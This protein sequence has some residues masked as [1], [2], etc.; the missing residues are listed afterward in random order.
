M[1]CVLPPNGNQKYSEQIVILLWF[2]SHIYK[3]TIPKYTD[4]F[5]NSLWGDKSN[6]K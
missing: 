3:K 4:I 2:G 5:C 1:P 6:E